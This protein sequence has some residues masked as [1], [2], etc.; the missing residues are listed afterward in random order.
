MGSSASAGGRTYRFLAISLSQT[1]ASVGKTAILPS[2]CLFRHNDM[3]IQ[4]GS[5]ACSLSCV[6]LESHLEFINQ[7]VQLP[8]A[9]SGSMQ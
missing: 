4:R 9:G 5:S 8:K 1:D 6:N 7:G 3:F 2:G